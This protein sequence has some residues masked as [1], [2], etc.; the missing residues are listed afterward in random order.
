LHLTVDA[1]LI[2]VDPRLINGF[3]DQP[4]IDQGHSI[5]HRSITQSDRS[6]ID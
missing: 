6:L 1:Y 2:D 5:N 3:V 4:S